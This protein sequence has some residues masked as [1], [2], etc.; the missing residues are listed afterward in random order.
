MN[1]MVLILLIV[2]SGIWFLGRRALRTRRLD[3]RLAG[4]FNRYHNVVVVAVILALVGLT[5]LAVFGLG[6]GI[7]GQLTGQ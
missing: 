2:A 4:V 5:V 3:P 6:G 7:Y 1:L